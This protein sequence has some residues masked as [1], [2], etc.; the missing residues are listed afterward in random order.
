MDDDVVLLMDRRKTAV[1][2]I[3]GLLLTVV[4]VLLIADGNLVA[5]VVGI[6]GVAFFGLSL[7]VVGAAVIRPRM[8]L[9]IGPVGLQFGGVVRSTRLSVPWDAIA[10]VRIYRFKGS[11]LGRGIKMLGIVPADPDAALWRRGRLSRLNTRLAGVPA[12]IT[13]RSVSM[14]LEQVAQIMQRF[15]RDLSVDYGDPKGSG[16]RSRL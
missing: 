13:E 8:V 12:S 11:A 7:V 5:I 16:P 10:G 3:G 14:D 6:L 1:T 4:S 15:K 9:T 2:A